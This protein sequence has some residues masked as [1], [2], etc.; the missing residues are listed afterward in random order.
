MS[1]RDCVQCNA[2]TKQGTSCKRTTCKYTTYCWQHTKSIRN[3]VIKESNI[4][5]AGDGLYT[6][7][8]FKKGDKILPY[9]GD[10]IDIP[11]DDDDD[12]LLEYALTIGDKII[13]AES[14]QSELTRYSNDCRIKNRRAGQCKNNNAQFDDVGNYEAYMV[15]TKNIKAGEEIFTDYGNEYWRE[16]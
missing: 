3:F 13:N 5:G 6:L 4:P 2:L 15:A 12:E 14:T 8:N 1:V 9:T 11:S 7:K 10:L 16:N